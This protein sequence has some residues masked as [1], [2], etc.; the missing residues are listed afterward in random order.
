MDLYDL[1]IGDRVKLIDGPVAL[2]LAETEDGNWIK[3][4][5]LESPL[6]P[7]L[8][9]SEDLCH[10]DELREVTTPSRRQ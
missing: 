6:N 9:G 8:V 3:V 4:R 1:K 7:T 10:F 2:V 5:Y